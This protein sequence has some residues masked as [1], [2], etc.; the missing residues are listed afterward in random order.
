MSTTVDPEVEE[1]L[2]SA[3][4]HRVTLEQYHRM[5]E[6]GVLDE[7]DR[8]E[9]LNG[10]MIE[11]SPQSELHMRAIV[12]LTKELNRSLPDDLEVRPQGP[13]TFLPDSEPEPDLAV[14]RLAETRRDRHPSTA[15]LVIEVSDS[16]LRK[17]RSV[18]SALYARAG[19]P[20]YWIVNVRDGV[21]EAN[22][23][24]DAATG[25]YQSLTTL[26]P[27]DV[28]SSP[29]LPGFSFEVATLFGG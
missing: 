25:R 10:V 17:D 27:G 9:L 3:A 29:L 28:L 2:R 12:L 19:I 15:L 13:L 24:P 16:T 23:E 11:M 20:E 6:T 21:V 4:V 7:D 1:L 26:R 22:A 8:V 18:K 14:V 5:I